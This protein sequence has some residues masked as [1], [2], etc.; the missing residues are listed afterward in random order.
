MT[1][2]DRASDMSVHEP[3][4]YSCGQNKSWTESSVIQNSVGVNGDL[5]DVFWLKLINFYGEFLV[6]G[7]IFSS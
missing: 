2:A 1:E 3:T 7:Y 5:T 4:G 6:F